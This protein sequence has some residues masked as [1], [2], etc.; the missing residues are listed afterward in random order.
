MK[1]RLVY[2]PVVK[3]GTVEGT[4]GKPSGG[5]TVTRTPAAGVREPTVG[6]RAGGREKPSNPNVFVRFAFQTRR[7]SSDRGRVAVSESPGARFNV[8]SHPSGT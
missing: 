3:S 6:T 2:L 5:T 1:V 8:P 4:I 7:R